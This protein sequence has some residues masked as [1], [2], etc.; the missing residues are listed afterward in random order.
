MLSLRDIMGNMSKGQ[1][2]IG[3]R[4]ILNAYEQIYQKVSSAIK[5]LGA[6]K[7]ASSTT[8]YMAIP[9]EDKSEKSYMV[10]LLIDSI[11]KFTLDT[12]LKIYSNAPSFLFNFA[13]IFNQKD[14]LLFPNKYANEFLTM[15]PKVRNPFGTL[16]F[17]KHVFSAIRFVSDYKLSRIINEFNGRTIP[18]VPTIRFQ[19]NRSTGKKE[20]VS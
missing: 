6:K 3:V 18:N 13:Y 9:S 16:G 2:A 5:I 17:E 14:S 11:D 8:V 7:S 15:P 1:S 20:L 4:H 12:K 19:L 10:V